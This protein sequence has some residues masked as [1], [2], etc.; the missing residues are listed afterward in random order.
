MRRVSPKYIPREYLLVD[1]YT[2][3]QK[4][5]HSIVR[6]LQELFRHPYDEQPFFGE[7]YYKPRP[8][9]SHLQ[10]GVGFMS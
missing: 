7:K 9:G 6:A 1:A 2:A 10:G 8:R 4:G 5:D 3:A